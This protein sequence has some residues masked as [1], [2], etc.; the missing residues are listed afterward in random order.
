VTRS[1]Y[2]LHLVLPVCLL[3]WAGDRAVPWASKYHS[4]HQRVRFLLRC[5]SALRVPF[6]GT[7]RLR[8]LLLLRPRTVW[9]ASCSPEPSPHCPDHNLLSESIIGPQVVREVWEIAWFA[10][11]FEPGFWSP[12]W[13]QRANSDTAFLTDPARPCQGFQCNLAPSLVVPPRYYFPQATVPRVLRSLVRHAIVV[14][15]CVWRSLFNG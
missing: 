14:K 1:V 10:L 7:D 6:E 3:I 11:Q 2:I 8:F 5:G 9:R 12:A 4:L 15:W 13:V